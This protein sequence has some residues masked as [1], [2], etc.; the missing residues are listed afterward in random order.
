ML[1]RAFKSGNSLAVRIP[2][3]L[4]VVDAP[5]DVEIERIGDSLV[6]RPVKARSL[7]GVLKLFASFPADFVTERE[8]HEEGER[9]WTEMRTEARAD[10]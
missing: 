1:G 3:E 4:G 10:K 5:G 8:F 9:E 2:R 7:D 6:I